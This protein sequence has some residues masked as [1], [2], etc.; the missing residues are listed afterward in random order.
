MTRYQ[1]AVRTIALEV[2]KICPLHCHYCYNYDRNGAEKKELSTSQWLD[3]IKRLPNA[4]TGVVTGGEPFLRKDIFRI[5]Y[6]FRKKCREMII[7]TSGQIMNDIIIEGLSKAKVNLQIQVSEL[8]DFYN[9]NTETGGAFENLERNIIALSRNGIPFSTSLVLSR[10][11]V[12]QLDRILSF[13]MAAGS[14]HILV[15]RYVPQSDHDNWKDTILAPDEYREALGVLN[16]FAR[17]NSIPISLGIPNLPCIADGNDLPHINMP[18]C[19]AGKDYFTIDEIGR[20]KIC[21]HHVKT[22]L[23]L[24]E[25]GFHEAVESLRDSI[26]ANSELPEMCGKCVDVEGCRGGCRSSAFSMVLKKGGLDPMLL[27]D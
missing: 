2:T 4:D 9:K 7:L 14:R 24:L 25:V 18:S 5:I 1:A 21:P 17:K 16:G 19:G 23:S 26:T 22:G 20:I 15:I 12:D 3:I 10:G 8:S 11:N 27:P 6:A 13:H